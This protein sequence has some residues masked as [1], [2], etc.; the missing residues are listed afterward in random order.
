MCVRGFVKIKILTTREFLPAFSIYAPLDGTAGEAANP[1]VPLAEVIEVIV[2]G[3]RL[4]SEQFRSAP[5]TCWPLWGRL[6]VR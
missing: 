2:R 6:S 3:Y 1:H 4:D 5:R